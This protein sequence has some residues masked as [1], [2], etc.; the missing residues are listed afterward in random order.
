MSNKF[1]SLLSLVS[2]VALHRHLKRHFIYEAGKHEYRCVAAVTERSLRTIQKNHPTFI[3]DVVSDLTIVLASAKNAKRNA[4]VALKKVNQYGN[5]QKS[6]CMRKRCVHVHARQ[7]HGRLLYIGL[8]MRAARAGILSVH[9]GVFGPR[10]RLPR[11][12]QHH[13][14]HWR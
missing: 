5:L 14:A 1:T 3:E 9:V 10:A 12:I 2:V 13:T 4:D 7:L 6:V 8:Q 11:S